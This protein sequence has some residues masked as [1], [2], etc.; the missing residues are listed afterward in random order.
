MIILEYQEGKTT[1]EFIRTDYVN[2]VENLYKYKVVLA[3]SNGNGSLGEILSSP[4]V[5]KPSTGTTETFISIGSFDNESEAQS[6]LKY[7][8]TKFARTLLGVLKV[9]QDNN[10]DKWL[11]VPI[12][13]FT[14]K[15]DINWTLSVK[16][17]DKQLYKKYNLSDEEIEFIEE[18]AREME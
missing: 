7:V 5:E 4:L 13:D 6:C 9:T 2:E 12:Q 3:R 11:Y 17:I 1:K 18:K 16:E 15:S 14:D 8:K 10:A